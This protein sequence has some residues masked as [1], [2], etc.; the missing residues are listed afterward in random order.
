MI[1]CERCQKKFRGTH[2][3]RTHPCKEGIGEEKVAVSELR[4]LIEQMEAEAEKIDDTTITKDL[5][6]QNRK[7]KNDCNVFPIKRVEDEL[8]DKYNPRD[9][10]FN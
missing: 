2:C 9:F 3:F 1:E 4:H 10:G 7:L 8:L 6:V 5:L